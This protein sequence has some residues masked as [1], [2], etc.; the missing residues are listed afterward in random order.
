MG[1]RYALREYASCNMCNYRDRGSPGAW[2]MHQVS[3][4][5]NFAQVD[6]LPY[7]YNYVYNYIVY[8]KSGFRR[9]LVNSHRSFLGTFIAGVYVES[10]KTFL[11]Q[12]VVC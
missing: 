2:T 8:A 10:I 6:L 5:V 11:D 4:G 1:T 7:V 9:K 12:F 3:L